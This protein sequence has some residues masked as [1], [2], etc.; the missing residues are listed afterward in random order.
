MRRRK[1]SAKDFL[2]AVID[3]LGPPTGRWED[4]LGGVVLDVGPVPGRPATVLI[5]ASMASRSPRGEAELMMIVD[6]A[7][8]LEGPDG[9]P[10]W[11]VRMLLAL[12]GS[13]IWLG[14]T[15]VNDDPP[16]P[17]APGTAL[18]GVLI[19]EPLRIDVGWSPIDV[20]GVIPLHAAELEFKLEHGVEALRDRLEEAGVTEVLRP[21][22]PSVV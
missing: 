8:P 21:D 18:C 15:A 5:T 2:R 14:E 22:R 12:T 11:P 19:D 17:Y 6:P 13:A 4:G 10:A 1:R 16:Q 3:G 20:F 7:L 9:R